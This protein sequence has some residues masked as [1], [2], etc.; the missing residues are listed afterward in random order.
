MNYKDL[1]RDLRETAALLDKHGPS[2]EG[3][4]LATKAA[5]FEKQAAKFKAVVQD[6][7]AGLAPGIRDLERLLQSPEKK[8]FTLPVLKLLFK[9]TT[10]H[11]PPLAQCK[12]ATTLKKHWL[13]EIKSSGR[14]ENAL[15]VAQRHLAQ[16]KTP[17]VPVPKDAD[18]LRVEFN[19]LGGLSD[20]ELALEL[21]KRFK[22]IDVLRKLAG[23]NGVPDAKTLPKEELVRSLMERAR[24]M[25]GH[26]L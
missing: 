11:G 10:G 4:A 6:A 16:L 7:A 5:A 25:H 12:T 26:L 18:A 21:D 17:A 24:R 20:E 9:E 23:A 3:K 19:R 15:S 2:M 8:H 14:G 22:K 1:A 13:A